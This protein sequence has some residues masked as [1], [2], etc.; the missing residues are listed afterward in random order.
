ML[1]KLAQQFSLA[2][3]AFS[4]RTHQRDAPARAIHFSSK[5]RIGRAGTQAHAAVNAL[6]QKLAVIRGVQGSGD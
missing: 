2:Q 6:L 1:R 4:G 3:A 5:D